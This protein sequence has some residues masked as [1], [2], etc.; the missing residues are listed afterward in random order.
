MTSFPYQAINR[1]IEQLPFLKDVTCLGV[2]PL[3][4]RRPGMAAAIQVRG[5]R[6]TGLHGPAQLVGKKIKNISCG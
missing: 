1:I 6:A 2:S 3:R 5:R 4:T